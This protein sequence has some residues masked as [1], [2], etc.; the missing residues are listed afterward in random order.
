MYVCL[1]CSRAVRT[2]AEDDALL[3]YWFRHCSDKWKMVNNTKKKCERK[4]KRRRSRNA[5]GKKS[6]ENYSPFRAHCVF[7]QIRI[8]RGVCHSMVF[9]SSRLTSSYRAH[10]AHTPHRIMCEYITSMMMMVPMAMARAMSAFRTAKQMHLMHSRMLLPHFSFVIESD[11]CT[12]FHGANVSVE[13]FR[14]QRC[15][16]TSVLSFTASSHQ[17]RKQFHEERTS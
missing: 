5:F 7:R 13:R 16:S 6:I 1:Q 12:F 9:T 3:H 15:Q 17:K 2:M 14:G 8:V 11:D 4:N 10:T